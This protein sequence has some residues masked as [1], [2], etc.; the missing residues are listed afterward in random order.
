[1]DTR[2]FFLLRHARAH[3]PGIEERLADLTEKQLRTR[4]H[5]AVNSVAWLFWHVARVEDMAINRLVEDRIQVLDEQEWMPRLDVYR[6]DV[7]QAM[8]FDEVDELSARANLDA[9]RSYWSAV[10]R[11]TTDVVNALTP[12]GLDETVDAARLR[13]AIFDEGAIQSDQK[14]DLYRGWSGMSRG[15][16]LAHHCLT[17]TYY[18]FGEIDVIRGLWGHRGQF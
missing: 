6:R 16:I 3:G 9:L 7:G 4:P 2:Q 15:Y 8:T 13:H 17:H 12:G 5:P 18:H 10:G 1:M 14:E 11:R